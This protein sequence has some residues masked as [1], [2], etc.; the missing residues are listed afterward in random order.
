MKRSYLI[1]VLILSVFHPVLSIAADSYSDLM[2]KAEKLAEKRYEKKSRAYRILSAELD[3]IMESADPEKEKI[4]KLKKI[5]GSLQE[6]SASAD[7]QK[8]SAVKKETAVKVQVPLPAKAAPVKKKTQAQILADLHKK[9]H[10]GDVQAQYAL[11]LHYEK[12]FD[13]KRKIHYLRNAATNDHPQANFQM[14]VLYLE[15]RG[16][17]RANSFAFQYF[18][19]AEKLGSAEVLDYLAWCYL[20]GKGTICDP[21]KALKLYMRLYK[22]GNLKAGLALGNFCYEGRIVPKDHAKAVRYLQDALRGK[23]QILYGEFPLYSV[24]GKIF[25]R[26]EHG[27]VKD[28]EQA[29]IMLEKA[30]KENDAETFLLLGR[31][32]MQ[33][34]GGAVKNEKTAFSHFLQADSLGCIPARAML[35][36]MYLKGIGTVRDKV[37]AAQYLKT[38]ADHGDLECCRL[39]GEMLYA[40]KPSLEKDRDA[41]RYFRI[42]AGKGDSAAL[43]RCGQMALE[44]R[45]TE[46]NLKA[47]A[48]Y[49]TKAARKG[50]PDGLYFCGM[51]AWKK[52]NTKDGFSY[53]V[54]AADSGHKRAVHFVAEQLLK[55]K[56]PVPQ[57]IRRGATYLQKLADAGDPLAQ[58]RLAELY[59]YGKGKLFTADEE[60]AVKYYTLA[61]GQKRITSCRALAEIAYAKGDYD[62]A[63]YWA[64]QALSLGK[65]A[66]SSAVIGRMY[67]YGQGRKKDPAKALQYLLEDAKRGSKDSIDKVGRL[68]YNAG[69]LPEA[70]KYLLQAST[71]DNA[72]ILFM[73]G[74]INY[75]G[76]R[77]GPDYPRALD[78][79]LA[80]AGKGNVDA[81]LLIGRMYHRGEG[82]NQDFAKAKSYFMDAARRGSAEGL[83]LVGSMYY[84]GEGV[85][86][87]YLEA[88]NYFKKAAEKDH[89]VA[90]QY[91]AIMYKEGIGVPRNNQEAIR[92]RK[93]IRNVRK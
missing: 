2:Y 26:G 30:S 5:I 49:Y 64:K 17:P 14:G 78:L 24:L 79:L 11:A 33:G 52:G 67:Y 71:P 60:K 83:Y 10:H 20:K 58:E 92:W 13:D 6:S 36:K 48:E 73:L 93:R 62:K 4:A 28:L 46:K 34:E 54:T 65:D 91:I 70:E 27:S 76:I 88:M 31:M 7:Q 59:R 15:G 74:R 50:H 40:E 42:L 90:M 8:K 81:M 22:D 86:P 53:L 45:G 47:A 38:A 61:A 57:N 51:E 56:G 66:E 9:A 37:L 85:S 32:Y 25:Y 41:F 35:G 12:E 72:E 68:Y 69:K 87:D 16:V 63:F 82:M 19:K 29:R 1:P 44:G 3:R 80:A 18:L 23:D 84:N 77:S 43:S 89:I 55:E 21:Q 75:V 39:L